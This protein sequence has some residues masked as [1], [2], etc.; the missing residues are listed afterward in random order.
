MCNNIQT[1]VYD[2]F[3]LFA[4][5]KRDRSRGEVQHAQHESPVYD[6]R[7]LTIKTYAQLPSLHSGAHSF[8]PDQ[9]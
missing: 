6:R 3:L 7:E 4:I 8:L 5:Q 1:F 2:A 9:N